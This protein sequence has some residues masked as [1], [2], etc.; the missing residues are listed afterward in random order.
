MT[1]AAPPRAPGSMQGGDVAQTLGKHHMFKGRTGSKGGQG[2][3]RMPRRAPSDDDS[4]P[5][6]R[7]DGE[8]AA[9]GS[10]FVTARSMAGPE[11]QGRSSDSGGGSDDE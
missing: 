11:Y 5:G 9:P 7:S 8:S 4:T 3:F 6:A 2:G 1:A 10:A